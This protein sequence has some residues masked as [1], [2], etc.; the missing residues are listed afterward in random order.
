MVNNICSDTVR[1]IA[2]VVLTFVAVAVAAQSDT[3]RPVIRPVTAA[4]TV[5]AG[6][7]HLADTYI[8]PLK[9]SGW[10]AAIGYERW[11][12]MKMNP[13]Q[14][15]MHLSVRACVDRTVNPSGNATMWYG[16]IDGTWGM[17]RRRRI[18]HALSVGYGGSASLTLGCIYSARNG[19]NPASARAAITLDATGYVNYR[20]ALAGV[21]VSLRYQPTLPVIGAFFSPDYGELYYEIYLGNRSGLAHCAWWGNYFSIDNL[22]TADL[23]LGTTALRLGYRLDVCTTHVNNITSRRISHGAV[24]GVT[25]EWISLYPGRGVDPLAQ[26]ISANY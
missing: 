14:W 17:M 1:W 8:T 10:T 15:V 7:A 22:L 11:Q 9:Y 3:S 12:A 20:T 21:P 26:I 24:V 16:G 4:Y 5:E 25:G 13:R 6:S 18:T 19:N 23:Q 2:S